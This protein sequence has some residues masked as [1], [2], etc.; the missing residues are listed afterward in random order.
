MALQ[1]TVNYYNLKKTNVYVL[2]LDASKAFDR[3]EYCKLFKLLIQ[4]GVSPLIV[5]LLINMY[6]KQRLR[7]KWNN[8]I[9]DAFNATN[10]V[11]QGGVLSPILFAIYMD[12]LLIRLKNSGIGCHIGNTFIAALAYADDVT[13]VCPT[14]KSLRMLVRICEFYADEYQVVFNG[15][16]SKLLVFK[17]RDCVLPLDVYI[18]VNGQRVMCCKN[19]DHLGHNMSCTDKEGLL[20]GAL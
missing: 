13:L 2:M 15:R 12:E 14:M 16:K 8:V 20:K 6:T 9:S 11:K 4:K 18:Y 1:E 7:V 3:V 10:G 17:G 19:A 5:R